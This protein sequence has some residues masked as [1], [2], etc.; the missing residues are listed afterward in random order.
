[1]ADATDNATG[2][3]GHRADAHGDGPD[4]ATGLGG[5]IAPSSAPAAAHP[6]TPLKHRLCPAP[7]PFEPD[8]GWRSMPS[9]GDG[10]DRRTRS[11][12]APLS[13]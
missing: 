11:Q 6:Q 3:Q 9:G 4:R 8:V 1:M 12:L 13:V 10:S 5:H 2:D 7:A